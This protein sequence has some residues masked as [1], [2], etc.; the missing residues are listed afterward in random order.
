MVIIRATQK[1]RKYLPATFKDEY[2]SDSALGDWFVNRTIVDR[3]PLLLFVSSK[4]LL[5]MVTPARNVSTI[6]ERFA[7][8]VSERLKRLGLAEDLIRSEIQIMDEVT[9]APTNNRSVTGSMVDFAYHLPYYLPEGNWT[10]ENFKLAEDR[11]AEIPCRVGH[12]A[13]EAIWPAALAKELILE[14]WGAKR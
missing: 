7:E 8:L 1:V 14:K 10:D 4:S 13:K 9:V 2:I 5:P 3:K 6:T 12:S 11:L